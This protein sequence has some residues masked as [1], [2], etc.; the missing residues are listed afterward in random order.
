M[1]WSKQPA[2]SFNILLVVEVFRGGSVY[3]EEQKKI[4]KILKQ[5][6]KKFINL[7]R[8]NESKVVFF[9]MIKYIF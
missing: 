3:I 8:R 9:F 4:L 1:V 5:D 2:V 6:I 7:E